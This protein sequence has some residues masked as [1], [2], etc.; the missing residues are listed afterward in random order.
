MALT[1]TLVP[2]VLLF[3]GFPIF[4]ILL[5]TAAIAIIIFYSIP[6]TVL[7]QVMFGSLDSAALLAVPFFIFAG[8]IMAAGG[9]SGRLVAWAKSLFGSSKA[10]LPITTV[11]TCVVFG[12]ISGSSAAT[13]AAISAG[14][15]SFALNITLRVPSPESASYSGTPL[16]ST[17]TTPSWSK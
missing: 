16:R 11:A 1:M 2:I 10:S 3:L 5:A 12:A 15:S 4:V 7:H 14:G 6:L 9:I 13:V 8:E 17:T